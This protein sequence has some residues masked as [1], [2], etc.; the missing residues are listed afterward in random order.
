MRLHKKY[1]ISDHRPNLN[2][3]QENKVMINFIFFSHP[4]QI[5]FENDIERA[6][7]EE[8]LDKNKEILTFCENF[9]L[10][11]KAIFVEIESLNLILENEELH[12]TVNIPR[13]NQA[14]VEP[15]KLINKFSHWFDSYPNQDARFPYAILSC[16]RLP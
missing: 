14:K 5:I 12:F 3:I 16:K 2:T 11:A 7:I 6:K 13:Y 8:I 15:I 9:V 4:M 1:S 10:R